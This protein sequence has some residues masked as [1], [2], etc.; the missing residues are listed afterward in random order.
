MDHLANTSV[1]EFTLKRHEVIE[2][3]DSDVYLFE[4]D[5]LG[6]P[7]LAIKNSDTNKT[8]SVAF[9]TIPKD[10]TGVAH[11]LEHAVLMGSK[12]YPVKD[13]FGEMN[14]GGLM[15][16]LN[17][18]TGS[19]ITYYPFATR[20]QKEYFNL[21]DVYC[22]VVFHPLLAPETFEQEGWHYHKEA[23]DQPLRYQGVVFNEMKGAYSDPIRAIF[24]HLFKGLMP[25][26]TYAH[27]SG[28]DPRVIPELS[29][30]Q[31]CNFHRDHYHPSN[32]TFFLYGDAELEKELEYLQENFLRHFNE[33]GE[34]ARIEPG[35]LTDAPTIIH[36]RYGIESPDTDNRTY[37]AVGTRVGTVLDRLQNAA[38]QVIANI[39]F[40][41][42]GS[43][44]KNNIVS[45]GICKD[46]G[47]LHLA[48]SCFNTVMITYLVGSESHHLDT[49]QSLYHD[50]LKSMVADGLEKELVLSELNKYEFA[51]REDASKAQRGLDL[52]SKALAAF[53]YDTDPF[54]TLRVEHLL[55]QVRH[56]ALQENYFEELINSSLLENPARV[57]VV[58][59]P[60]PQKLQETAREE[61]AHLDQFEKTLNEQ[62]MQTLVDRTH[63]LIKR[64]ST[65]NDNQT[66]QLLPQLSRADLPDRIDFHAA[67]AT[68]LFGQRF[69]VSELPTNRISYLDIGLD[70]GCLP[71]RYLPLLDLFGAVI[72]EIGTEKLDYM[73]FA[74]EAATCTGG[75]NHA[76][77]TYARYGD[78]DTIK[79]VFWISLKALP[80]YLERA[81]DLLA[82]LF[83]GL[84]LA[85]RTRVQEIVRR[86]FAWSEHSAQSEG[87][88]LP[89]TRVFSHLSLAARYQEQV[90]GITAYRAVKDIATNYAQREGQLLDDLQHM[91]SI[92]LNRNNM[93]IGL[94]AEAEEI[95]R[96]EDLGGRIVDA[97]SSEELS[98]VTPPGLPDYDDHEAFVTAAEIVFAVQGG[99]VFPEASAYNGSFEVLKTYLSRDYLWNSV[100][101]MGGAYGCFIQFSPVTG[102]I[103]IISY[104]DPQVRKTYDAYSRIPEIIGGIDISSE[105]LEQL[106]IGTY[107]NFDPHQSP[108]ARG[109][110]ARNEFLSNIT[111]EMKQQRVRE[112]TATSV[113][114]LRSY[115]ES[116]TRML[117]NSHRAII[118]NRAKIE[119]D[120]DLF[121]SISEL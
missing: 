59:E 52:M 24:Q 32:A 107:G 103:G 90:N 79:N 96:F 70:L 25:G 34:R 80:E 114:D 21:M 58:L 65:P 108:A 117:D 27:E 11:I 36:D 43:P 33:P 74:K 63:E 120:K 115:K 118:G 30:E 12:K 64:Q 20:N 76:I 19:D 104:R 40:N 54:E 92:L 44:L 55:K 86:E 81:I 121:D 37:L 111:T 45:S 10:S 113:A 89:A 84:S 28:G 8:F 102:N 68:T 35:R 23:G 3:I 48:S 78:M 99:N 50:S 18:M 106:I 41:S 105:S 101:Q 9:N 22:D 2:E 110:T 31:F 91:A 87:Y 4:H 57:T 5:L 46:F 82:G 67:K 7:L 109:A 88:S 75:L 56:K 100:R 95:A 61:Q 94:T 13:V 72:T 93:V 16:F 69:L 1:A 119:H 112:I 14:K 39:L 77:N 15:T 97:L 73:A 62:D 17:A 60:D 26:S 6:C 83:D 66:L 71:S 53:K 98:P 47:G 116:F 85:D 49:F 38:F 51:A 42:D 29:Y